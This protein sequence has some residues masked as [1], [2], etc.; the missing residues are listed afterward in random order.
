MTTLAPFPRPLVIAHRGASGDRPENTF[1]AFAL[2]VEQGRVCSHEC[3]NFGTRRLLMSA[4]SP[5]ALD[6]DLE[7]DALGVAYH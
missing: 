5:V 2:A 7:L 1:P 3:P 4:P 6:R